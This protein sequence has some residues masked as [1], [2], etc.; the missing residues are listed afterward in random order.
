[1]A[2]ILLFENDAYITHGIKYILEKEGHDV[3]IVTNVLNLND[4]PEFWESLDL[5]IFDLMMG[6]TSL[7]NE[8]Q[9]LTEK[10]NITGAV[11]L[12]SVCTNPNVTYLIITGLNNEDLINKVK[13]EYPSTRILRKPFD[14]ETL[15]KI[16]REIFNGN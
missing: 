8:L 6:Y 16:V 9:D 11:V 14:D 7:P 4:E 5:V 10:G 15:L 1:M 12:Q 13:A 3:V 2:K